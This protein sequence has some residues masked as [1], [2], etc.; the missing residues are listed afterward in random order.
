MKEFGEQ[1]RGRHDSGASVGYGGVAFPSFLEV[2]RR[3]KSGDSSVH[4]HDHDHNHNHN[5]RDGR[6][7]RT[8]SQKSVLS[9]SR[10]THRESHR[11][12]RRIW[13]KEARK[14]LQQTAYVEKCGK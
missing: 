10:Y 9:E 4:D 5:N 3:L 6:R 14:I 13:R 11:F 2:S 7:R 8:R 12:S 1:R